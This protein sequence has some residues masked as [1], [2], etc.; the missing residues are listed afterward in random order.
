ME[1][2][3]K[4]KIARIEAGLT[5]RQLCGEEIT[6]NMLSQ[7]EH[8]TAK[9]SMKT[10]Q[11]L[12]A[13]LGKS[14]SFFLD[15]EAVLSPNRQLMETVR[16]YFDAQ[17]YPEAAQALKEYQAPDPV[18]DREKQLLQALVCLSL[19]EQAVREKRSVY[20]RELL[21]K[22]ELEGCYCAEAL[23]RR[24][25]LLWGKTGIDAVSHLLPGLDEELLLRAEEAFGAKKLLRAEQL[26]DAAEDQSSPEWNLLR[27]QLYL[28][29]VRYR[30]AAACFHLAEETFPKETWFRLEHCYREM[31]DYKRAYEY[32]CKQ[33]AGW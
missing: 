28:A 7:I 30:E 33:K 17:Q 29:R 15:E 10:L 20:A 3:E 5:Q 18:Y 25:L 23:Q 22:V 8:G 13:R 26:L 2:G 6:R 9:P 14:V 21:S 32:A 4:L 31:E 19:A 12:A 11:Y 16:Q 27:G 24:R 1:L